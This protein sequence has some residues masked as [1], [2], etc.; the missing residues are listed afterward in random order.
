MESGTDDPKDLGSKKIGNQ[1]KASGVNEG[2][3]GENLPRNYD[4]AKD[5][6]K[7]EVEKD[8]DG[9][10]ETVK[11]NRDIDEKQAA[12]VSENDRA[13]SDGRIVDKSRG[14]Q[15]EAEN[16]ETAENRDFNNDLDED[17]YDKDNPENKRSR[18]NI[19][20]GK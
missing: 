2:F 20:F 18:G 15:N 10:Q 6:M 1:E 19:D 12:P 4:P 5:K 8:I 7:E 11:R 16:M 9:N 14:T 13:E 3:S 17:R